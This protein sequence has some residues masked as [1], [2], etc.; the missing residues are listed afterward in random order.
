MKGMVQGLNPK[1]AFDGTAGTYMMK[2]QH[3]NTI[4][5]FKPID[6]EAYAPN[7]P[8]GY[9]GEFGQSSFRNGILSGEGVIREVASSLLDHESFSG[10]PKTI[11]A[12]AMHPS[13]NYSSQE[14]DSSDFGND[15]KNYTSTISSLVNPSLSENGSRSASNA[16]EA[17]LIK[18]NSP[19]MKYGSLQR[20]VNAD[21]LASN[22]SSDLF[23]VDE[24][25]KIG[26][27]DLR[28]MNLDRNDGNIL[29][30]V[31]QRKEDKKT[32]NFYKLTPIDHSLSIPDNLE[33]YSY[34]IC[35]MDWE[36]SEV[37]FSQKSRDFIKGLDI[38]KDIQMLDNLFKFRKI[39][40]RNIRITGI[41]LKRGAEAGLSLHQIGK[42]LCREDDYEDDPEPSLVEKMVKRAQDMARNMRSFS[43][44]GF[45]R[46]I[47]SL[48]SF[49]KQR[50]EA[51]RSKKSNT[52]DEYFVEPRVQ[53]NKTQKEETPVIEQGDRGFF[54]SK[55]DSIK[56]GF[57]EFNQEEDSHQEKVSNFEELHINKANSQN[58]DF[59]DSRFGFLRNVKKLSTKRDRAQSQ[60]DTELEFN[61]KRYAP[62]PTKFRQKEEVVDEEKK[63]SKEKKEGGILQ[64]HGTSSSSGDDSDSSEEND[65][66]PPIG[67]TMSLPRI[68]ILENKKNLP[69]IKEEDE[70]DTAHKESSE[71][72]D[73]SFE[74][75]PI[76]TDMKKIVSPLKILRE[77]SSDIK[78]K[79]LR[80][81]PYDEQFF[82]YFQVYLDEAIEKILNQ[83]QKNIICR[84]RSLSEV[85]KKEKSYSS[86]MN[87][88]SEDI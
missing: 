56:K 24:V 82:Y 83:S 66:S 33:V 65:K 79:E 2:D 74:K 39:C 26:I 11:F 30:K 17:N 41:I 70:K 45:K 36:Q 86:S 21:D 87:S 12:E 4:A 7:N 43:N 62:S 42:M 6:E 28:I 31:K 10:V 19:K 38:L 69:H 84:A 34:D 25:H 72:P 22:Y 3:R 5:I 14:M 57:A 60:N 75:S 46:K 35:W 78:E 27:L 67:R 18:N 47:K 13:F 16:G 88:S 77:N 73:L 37:P 9:I 80:D 44:A 49:R 58:H 54:S 1:L 76:L 8:R 55:I 23:S 40:L 15:N 63:K 20:F 48:E 64:L 32:I 68:K 61:T 71:S 85:D 59:K 51:R 81:S 52:N 50:Q 53:S 29:V